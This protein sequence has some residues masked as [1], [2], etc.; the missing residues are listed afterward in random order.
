MIKELK[1]DIVVIAVPPLEQIK[2]LKYLLNNKIQFFCQKPI[3]NNLNDINRFIKLNNQL[4]KK[5]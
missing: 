2:I 3:A 4:R 1:P 5:T